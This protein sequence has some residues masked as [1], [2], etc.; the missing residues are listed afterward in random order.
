MELTVSRTTWVVLAVF[1]ALAF[2]KL[3]LGK[4]PQEE[5]VTMRR[6]V[7]EGGL[8][9][10]VRSEGEFTAGHLDGARNVPIDTLQ[11]R[12]EELGDPERPIVVYCASGVRSRRAAQLLRAHEFQEVYDL[13]P[14]RNWE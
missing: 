12:L 11:E 13:G 10:D 3:H 8:L 14:W 2:F 5:L 1:V 7:A 4:R 9:L 6:A